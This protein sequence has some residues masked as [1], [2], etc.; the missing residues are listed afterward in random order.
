MS[1]WLLDLYEANDDMHYYELRH[2]YMFIFW[3]TVNA[4]AFNIY[5]S[6]SI[7]C[8]QHAR[9]HFEHASDSTAALEHEGTLQLKEKLKKQ[10]YN[11]HINESAQ[12]VMQRG[13]RH[14][15]GIFDDDEE[16]QDMEVLDL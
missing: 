7:E 5:V 9:A 12:S 4:M 8:F 10:G 15:L 2:R 11:L 6:R 14:S 1:V 3:F 13:L 16:E